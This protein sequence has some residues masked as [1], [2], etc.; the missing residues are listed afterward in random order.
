VVHRPLTAP[1]R[2]CQ[3]AADRRGTQGRSHQRQPGLSLGRW[4][5]GAG[6]LAAPQPPVDLGLS[7]LG[8]FGAKPWSRINGGRRLW[9]AQSRT[10]KE[11]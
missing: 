8:P 10:I 3:Q 2:A 5:L 9:F 11:A 1:G 7:R 6:N 4:D